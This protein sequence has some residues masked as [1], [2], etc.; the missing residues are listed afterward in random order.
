MSVDD[1]DKYQDL[2][3]PSSDN[4]DTAASTM[5]TILG[6]VTSV[7]GYAAVISALMLYFGYIRTRDLYLFFGVDVGAL[8][9]SATDYNLRA[10]HLFFHPV[11]WITLA[12]V[13]S[14]ALSA[15]A[16]YVEREAGRKLRI[17][18]RCTLA[19]MTLATGVYAI[20]GLLGSGN[21]KRAATA[22][23][24]CAALAIIQYKMY[25]S[26]RVT[27]RS[28]EMV[29]TGGAVLLIGAAAFWWTTIYAQDVGVK[30]AHDYAYGSAGRG[31]VIYSKSQPILEGC[32]DLYPHTN[33]ADNQH[34]WR[35]IC[36]GYKVLVYANDR[37][38][39]FRQPWNE[40]AYTVI[41]P[42]GDDSIQVRLLG[43]K[44]S[45]K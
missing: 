17:G 14:Y 16:T 8:H 4:P 12:V 30:A 10:A 27:N 34:P 39:L 3:G 26:G 40:H 24:V 25:R 9:L 6:L 37:W 29:L 19:L 5:K 11:V 35:Y 41:L 21:G 38:F 33:K 43:D 45:D 31:I 23:G 15:G 7:I 20:R 32:T 13:A 18:L 22:L 1:S 28:S 42:A 36:V 2:S 44:P